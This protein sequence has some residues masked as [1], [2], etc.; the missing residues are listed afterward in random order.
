MC[1]LYDWH[2]RYLLFVIHILVAS[3]LIFWFPEVRIKISH[4]WH[5]THGLIYFESLEHDLVPG[6]LTFN[7]KTLLQEIWYEIGT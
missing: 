3:E 5:S 4:F 7:F 1:K 6:T 2:T